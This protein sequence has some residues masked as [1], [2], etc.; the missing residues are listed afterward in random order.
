M[1]G[2]SAAKRP[3]QVRFARCSLLGLPLEAIGFSH[4]TPLQ[5]GPTHFENAVIEITELPQTMRQWLRHIRL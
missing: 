5:L 4:D 1:T 3:D 2:Y